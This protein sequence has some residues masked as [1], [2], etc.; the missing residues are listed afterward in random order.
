MKNIEINTKAVKKLFAAGLLALSMSGCAGT[1]KSAKEEPTKGDKT[2][3]VSKKD[4]KTGFEYVEMSDEETKQLKAGDFIE[5]TDGKT[6][7]VPNRA[8]LESLGYD[9][10]YEVDCLD[11]LKGGDLELY[12]TTF[13]YGDVAM[14]NLISREYVKDGQQREYIYNIKGI[15]IIKIAKVYEEDNKFMKEVERVEGFI[16]PAELYSNENYE[17]LQK[18]NLVSYV[19]TKQ[20]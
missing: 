14:K 3:E 18:L 10:E 11:G 9:F 20:R 15:H 5:S 6:I 1:T 4:D 7:K 19:Y 13:A 17:K 16:T 12:S 8:V 2:E